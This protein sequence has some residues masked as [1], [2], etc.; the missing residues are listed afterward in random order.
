MKALAAHYFDG[1][2][3]VSR[4]VCVSWADGLLSLE[5]NGAVRHV[6]LSRVRV[7]DR[8]GSAPRLIY[9]DDGGELSLSEQAAVDALA[10]E[11]GQGKGGRWVF[12]L[13][14]RYVVALLALL[15]TLLF[16]WGGVR[17]AV[18]WLAARAVQFVPLEVDASLGRQALFLLD[19]F[20]M[21][22]S[23][24]PE[25]RQAALRFRLA[26]LCAQTRACPGYRLV[27]RRGGEIGANA[28]ALP[29]GLVIVTDELVALAVADGEIMGV[30]LHELGHVQGRH[31]LRLG[32]SS[33]GALLIAQVLVGDLG[34]LGDVVS[35]LP[36]LLTQSAYSRDM[37]GEA[38]VFA[39]T[40]MR[41]ACLPPADLV[42]MLARLARGKG[43]DA[44]LHGL[45]AS[46]PGIQQR[47]AAIAAIPPDPSCVPRLRE[48]R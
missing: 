8:L 24:L 36:T 17:H 46:H 32:L 9:L 18:P 20:H 48:P 25:A 14:R 22:A 43:H 26:A 6:P 21:G 31:A 27:F 19:R 11:L 44:G 39:A 12:A 34:N 13:E 2:S 37:E 15:V 29:G 16:S 33:A 47:M 5:E 3:S 1:R 30:I 42:R 4:Q 28:L 23:R 10:S 38:D 41:G 7:A 35:I 45:L 40:V